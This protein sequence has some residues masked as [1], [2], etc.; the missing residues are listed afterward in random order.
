MAPHRVH[1]RSPTARGVTL[2]E[3]MVSLTILLVGILGTMQMQILAI[4][5]NSGA[6]SHT[7]ALQLARQFAAALEQ[8][9]PDDVRL[10]PH[11]SSETAPAAFGRLLVGS[12]TLATSGFSPY[13]DALALPGVATDG[14]LLAD[15]GKDPIEDLVRFQRRYQV[16]EISTASVGAGV[17]AI[18]VSV[19]YREPRLPG[20]REVVLLTQ[21]ANKGLSSAFASAYR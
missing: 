6:R 10:A 3:A 19:T 18:A 21:V 9:P 20:L 17:K 2:L 12:G 16:W 11:F 7:Q 13:A 1:P 14:D 5:S 8:L 15:H 4:T